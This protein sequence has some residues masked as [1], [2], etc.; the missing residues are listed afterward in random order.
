MRGFP[1]EGAAEG[2]AAEGAVAEAEGDGGLSS[3]VG[4]A[5]GAVPGAAELGA[6]AVPAPVP[7]PAASG[8]QPAASATAA[9]ARTT[10]RMTDEDR[11]I[12]APE[13]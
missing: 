11:F 6:G 5:A 13:V 8:V 4:V 12:V 7:V 1:V 2:E 10:L 9:A 3:V